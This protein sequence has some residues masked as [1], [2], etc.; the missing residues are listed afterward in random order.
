MGRYPQIAAEVICLTYPIT[1]T[2]DAAPIRSLAVSPWSGQVVRW[3]VSLGQGRW[4]A[5]GELGLW[6]GKNWW[7]ALSVTTSGG[8]GCC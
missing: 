3:L 8:G 2:A 6:A 4:N 7:M 5:G 1:S